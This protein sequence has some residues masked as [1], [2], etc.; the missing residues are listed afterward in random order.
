MEVK[1][2]KLMRKEPATSHLPTEVLNERKVKLAS[3]WKNRRPLKGLTDEEQ[4]KLLPNFIGVSPEADDF[5]KQ[6]NNFYRELTVDVPSGGRTLEVGV[7]ENGVPYNEEDYI[8]YKFA[9]AHPLVSKDKEEAQGNRTKKFFFYSPEKETKKINKHNKY[10]TKAYIEL[11][12]IE[13]RSELDMYARILTD[14]RPEYLSTE[15]VENLLTDFIDNDPKEFVLATKDK[16]VGLRSEVYDML[17]YDVIEKSGSQYLFVD[18]ILGQ[19]VD[20]IVNFMRDDR[21]SG[22]VVRM[23][24]K[25]DEEKN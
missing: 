25:L 15:Q 11:S 1:E 21:N 23:R 8:I 2:I 4:R 10:K 17:N 24:A 20:E 9:K 5:Q 12:K 6:V 7:D 19:T 18:E 13:E 22:V 16:F 14:S 3:V